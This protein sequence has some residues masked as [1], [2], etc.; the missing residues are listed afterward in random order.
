MFNG[1]VSSRYHGPKILKVV[2]AHLKH[3]ESLEAF[4]SIKKYIRLQREAKRDPL[5]TL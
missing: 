1:T 3:A 5:Q 4:K 2:A